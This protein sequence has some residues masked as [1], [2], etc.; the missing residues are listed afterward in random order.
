MTSE[1]SSGRSGVGRHRERMLVLTILC[2]FPVSASSGAGMP[3]CRTGWYSTFGGR[4]DEDFGGM[5]RCPDEG[6]LLVGTTWSSSLYSDLLVVRTDL[7]GALLWE[8]SPGLGFEDYGASVCRLTDSTFLVAGTTYVGPTECSDVFLIALDAS[9]TTIW[10]RIFG[11]PVEDFVYDMSPAG[12]GSYVAAG[13]RGLFPE[14]DALVMRFDS[15]G[16]INWERTYGGVGND[17]AFSARQAADG[18]FVIAGKSVSSGSGTMD[19]WILKVDSSGEPEWEATLGGEGF[20]QFRSVCPTQNGG[21]LAVGSGYPPGASQPDL[22]MAWFDPGGGLMWESFTGSEDTAESAEWIVA[23]ADG[24][25]LITG[26]NGFIQNP[27]GDI[28]LLKVDS[29]GTIQW[30]RFWGGTDVDA[31]CSL[32]ECTGDRSIVVGGITRSFG[33]GGFDLVLVGFDDPIGWVGPP[34]DDFPMLAVSPNPVRTGSLIGF[35]L[36]RSGFTRLRILDLSGRLAAVLSEGPLPE[37]EHTFPVDCSSLPSG[38][39]F[40]QLEFEGELVSERFAAIH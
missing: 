27:Q 35:R 1:R 21:A 39:Y 4:E 20:D 40:C 28:W 8:S 19:G 38:V 31:G 23:A 7:S 25:F 13:A 10:S 33:E 36:P 12:D 18:G 3:D 26:R 16:S 9:G 5:I 29:A 11:S 24:R 2:I 22:W 34:Q 14:M 15:T 30:E 17:C 32:V 6:F 37:G